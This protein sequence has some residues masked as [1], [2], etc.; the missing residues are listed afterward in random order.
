MKMTLTAMR[1]IIIAIAVIGL[2]IVLPNDKAEAADKNDKA[3]TE[4]INVSAKYLYLGIKGKDTFQLSISKSVQKD[5]EKHSWYVLE[6]KGDPEAIQ[7]D[8]KS[9]LVKAKSA[10]TA[11]VGCKLILTD[12]SV[13]Q[14]EA[15]IIVINNI[16]GVRIKNIPKDKCIDVGVAYDFNEEI[17]DTTA[18]K[19]AKASGI[20][21]W[22]VR[23]DTA[24][25][26]IPGD[27]GVITPKKEGKFSIRAVSFEKEQDYMMWLMNKENRKEK[28]T[29]ASEWVT[30]TAIPSEGEAANQDQLMSLL[31][32]K[33]IKRITI[34]KAAES[35]ID[36]PQG[37]YSGKTLIIQAK[38]ID[39][40]NRG[41]FE[42]IKFYSA[43]DIRWTEQGQNNQF[44]LYESI[45]HFNITDKAQVKGITLGKTDGKIP[46]KEMLDQHAE[47]RE[48]SLLHTF[49]PEAAAASNNLVH[50]NVS[51]KIDKIDVKTASS[52]YIS[53][54]GKAGQVILSGTADGSRLAVS[55]ATY[56]EPLADCLISLLNGAEEV[57]LNLTKDTKTE[58]ENLSSAA[59]VVN[60]GETDFTYISPG[61]QYSFPYKDGF[62]GAN[63]K[64]TYSRT[65]K[66]YPSKPMYV[67]A[68]PLEYGQKLFFSN[69]YGECTYNS[70]YIAGFMSWLLPDTVVT[71]TGS[72]V[73]KFT[74]ADTDHYSVVYGHVE[75]R[76][77]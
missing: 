39:I 35:G 30:I 43:Y 62:I 63:G 32:E 33:K 1:S 9:G 25:V 73:W 61:Y 16:T 50:V 47:L 28:I 24:D 67:I 23:T 72:F 77:K 12:R 51:G 6:K 19:K 21:R 13:V 57:K 7:L 38:N 26:G 10:G 70:I 75:V 64:A 54:G 17:L 4:Y 22:E 74:P 31:S 20:T 60:F 71:N 34:S 37:D 44:E 41:R 36:I 58:V 3:V 11:Y 69:L 56:I 5:V 14:A 59:V 15:Q 49:T 27:D 2:L 52:L 8:E 48:D 29:A 45:I 55:L 68:S 53:G 76:V 42:K 46:Y 65:I 18:G 40:S 66:L